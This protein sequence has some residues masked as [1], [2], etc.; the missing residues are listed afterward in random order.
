MSEKRYSLWQVIFLMAAFLGV[1]ALSCGTGLTIGYRWGKDRGRAELLELGLGFLEQLAP[2][3]L[4]DRLPLPELP[5]GQESDRP[6]LGVNFFSIT[7][8]LAS[9]ENLAT[10]EGALITEVIRGT[11]AARAGLEP[12]DV[13][14]AVAGEMI[15]L[16]EPLPAHILR[17]H[18]GDRVELDILRH[19][20]ALTVDVRLGRAP[21]D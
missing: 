18:P 4:L 5:F 2:R 3:S 20:R 7:P 17:L 19:D 10:D 16:D 12:G 13:I 6:Y 14:I 8:E 15:T 9:E 11:P 1:A 21:S